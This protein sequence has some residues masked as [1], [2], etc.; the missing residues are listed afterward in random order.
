MKLTL[1]SNVQRICQVFIL[2]TSSANLIDQSLLSHMRRRFPLCPPA[3]RAA[4][5]MAALSTASY[6]VA[7]FVPGFM[8]KS[9]A[10]GSSFGTRA[11]LVAQRQRYHSG[12][13]TRAR[14]S[15]ASPV[16]VM[17]EGWSRRSGSNA[18]LAMSSSAARDTSTGA[19]V[20]ALTAS[21]KAMGDEIR[22]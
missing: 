3:A 15:S 7:A 2:N 11:R 1:L 12:L 6:R 22:M 14:A 21:I 4:V 20:E 8:T 19:S 17:L 5:A 13:W 9:G 16:A 18:K 10:N